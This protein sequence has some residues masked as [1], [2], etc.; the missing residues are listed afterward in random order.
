MVQKFKN[1]CVVLPVKVEVTL[2]KMLEE[3]SNK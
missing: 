2:L 1:S 3:E